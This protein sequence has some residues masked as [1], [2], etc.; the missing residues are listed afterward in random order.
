MVALLLATALARQPPITTN[1]YQAAAS[2]IISK[3]L[4]NLRAAHVI[5]VIRNTD[6]PGHESQPAY[7]S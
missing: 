7:L 2:C 4:L 1:G 6:L 5:E 3:Q